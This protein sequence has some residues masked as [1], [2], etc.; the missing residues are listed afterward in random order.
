MSVLA[1][2]SV[3]LLQRILGEFAVDPARRD[4]W[5]EAAYRQ[6]IDVGIPFS[7]FEIETDDWVEIDDERDLRLAGDIAGRYA[8]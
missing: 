6:A 8:A 3:P 2:A 1:A 4:D 5:Y 7:A